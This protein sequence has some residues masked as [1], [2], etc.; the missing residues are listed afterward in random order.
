MKKRGSAATIGGIMRWERIQKA[1][2]RR[3]RRAKR[4]IA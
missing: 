4:D 3:Q 1:K 2:S